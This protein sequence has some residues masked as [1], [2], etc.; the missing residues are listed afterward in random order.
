[1]QAESVRKLA[2]GAKAF[3]SALAA[4]SVAVIITCVAFGIA[5]LPVP[6]IL[7]W[8]AFIGLLTFSCAFIAAYITFS[9][10]KPK[11]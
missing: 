11:A 9:L 3:I 6:N 5:S 1:M 10:S 2:N 7:V 4:M 8:M